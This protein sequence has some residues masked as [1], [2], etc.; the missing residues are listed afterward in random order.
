MLCCCT[1]SSDT[2][3][4]SAWTTYSTK[5]QRYI[6]L[7]PRS[8]HLFL[9]IF[10]VNILIFLSSY[11]AT[12]AWFPQGPWRPICAV[13]HQLP[14]VSSFLSLSRRIE[15]SVNAVFSYENRSYISGLF[16]IVIR[17]VVEK[18]LS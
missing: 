12:K 18:T 14:H 15:G 17:V 11:R 6:N 3:G 9:V 5:R 13:L 8:W 1:C 7:C 4:S 2:K 16:D 10:L